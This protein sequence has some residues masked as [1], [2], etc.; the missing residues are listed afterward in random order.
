MS[1]ISSVNAFTAAL[2][3]V[4]SPPSALMR[5]LA[6]C[7]SLLVKVS[8][9]LSSWPCKPAS[10]FFLP[11][12][13]VSNL[14]PSCL[15]M[16]SRV[17]LRARSF[18]VR[19]AN[20][21][22]CSALRWRRS[23]FSFL[24][25]AA[26]FSSN[27]LSNSL[28]FVARALLSACICFVRSLSTLPTIFSLV[29]LTRFSAAFR[30]L[31]TKLLW[32]PSKLCMARC[33]LLYRVEFSFSLSLA[34]SAASASDCFL[35]SAL[36][37]SKIRLSS[38]WRVAFSES[39]SLFSLAMLAANSSVLDLSSLLRVDASSWRNLSARP[40]AVSS[41]VFNHLP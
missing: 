27:F 34:K 22:A 2:L 15:P 31:S 6:S 7:S 4:A 12:I 30:V 8:L 17:F 23:F 35:V 37:S 10:P 18:W 20:S 21:E 40:A 5:S 25:A 33:S 28:S 14:P 41:V 26:W 39:K 11:A 16:A 38:D 3:A 29:A 19:D 36:T 1:L 13:S 24:E 32:R 9:V